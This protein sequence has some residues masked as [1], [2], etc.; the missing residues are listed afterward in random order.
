VQHFAVDTEQSLSAIV[1]KESDW[2]QGLE[3]RTSADR[4]RP[5]SHREGLDALNPFQIT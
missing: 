2:Q 3:D 1:I 4:L 5:R